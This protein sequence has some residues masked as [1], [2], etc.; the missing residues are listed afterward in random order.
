MDAI[1][2][3]I[4][5]LRGQ[6][7][8]EYRKNMKKNCF[9]FLLI[10]VLAIL[11]ISLVACTPITPDIP[12]VEDP[13]K[14]EDPT[15]VTFT[16]T[17]DSKGG[18][19]I[20]GYTD[21]EFGQ[22]VPA[23]TTNPT[24]EGFTFDC[25][26]LSNGDKVDFNTYT[27]YSNTTFYASWTAKSYDITAYLSD[28][29][30]KDNLLDFTSGTVSE[31]YGNAL[32]IENGDRYN[33]RDTEVD[34][35]SVK[36]LS[37][38][39]K[40]ETTNTSGQTLP[41][42]STTKEGDRF[43]YWY[44]YE[45]G[46]I[47]PLTKTLAKGSDSKTIE[48]LK[49]YKYDGSRTIYAMWYSALTNVTVKFNS[50]IDGQTISTEDIVLK[51]GDY[52]TAPE[53][54]TITGYDFNKWTY[55]KMKD[56]EF[57][58]DDDKN[59]IKLDM[60]FYKS[61]TSQGLQI[62]TSITEDNVFNLYA[63]WTTRIEIA[64]ASDLE[65][66]DDS[67]EN[68]QNANI[69]LTANV[70]LSNWTTKFTEGK[71]FKGIFNGN[72]NTITYTVSSLNDEYA[73]FFGINE[74][75]IKGLTVNAT[76]NIDAS[77]DQGQ[78]FIGGVVGQNKGVLG[79][80]TV[81]SFNAMATAAGKMLYVG[82]F[83]AVMNGGELSAS[84]TES[85]SISAT[86]G[87]V[88]AG[89]AVGL[90]TNGFVKHLIHKGDV[91]VSCEGGD[92]YAGA[93]AGK[94]S[95]GDY[96]EC[97][98]GSATVT[99]TATDNAYVGGV[100]GKI[101]NNGIEQASLENLTLSATAK[102]SYVGGI[103]GEGGSTI[104]HA[105]I[106]SLNATANGSLSAVVGGIV[107]ANYCES[108][109]RGQVQFSLVRGSLTAISTDG[110]VYAGGVS[111]QQNAGASSTN[112]A[113]SY[114]Y[115]ECTLTAKTSGASKIGSI[116]G[117]YDTK[118]VCA[119]VYAANNQSITLNDVVY[120]SENKNFE[121]TTRTDVELVTPGFETIQNA[122]WVNGKLKLNSTSSS[123]NLIWI[124]ADGSYPTLKFVE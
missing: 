111:G 96:K 66:L 101:L 25:W 56:G 117:V 19:A 63:N 85:V 27:V 86:G 29:K 61:A 21:V 50:G 52:L 120:D 6:N 41:V 107:G 104:K 47:I 80:M 102:N 4:L 11:V 60:E 79:A 35:V 113:V 87:E 16:V 91:T 71:S 98:L 31:Y 15:P 124:I 28:E 93:F 58:L 75:T 123:D 24:K 72:G 17:F 5:M 46:K 116:F 114:V 88:Y 12:N 99:V 49:G 42:P 13:N 18:T 23:P 44:Y 112:G 64:T 1:I 81:K 78:I 22:T 62:S 89:G 39:L 9:K 59:K 38:S 2:K 43:M 10:A 73:S 108:G 95:S 14:G 103:V 36:T 37:L 53:N 122:S 105:N 40:Y 119:N 32:S 100:A 3:N 26:T 97:A 69:Y 54:P 55:F 70:T 20:T 77:G 65:N 33:L 90:N 57:I 30:V 48:L 7:A 76:I 94:I 82:A 67:D 8:H 110:K 68:V 74:G 51:D 115:S 109:N 106:T 121:V 83:A 118:T 84:N 92:V 34:G 45:G